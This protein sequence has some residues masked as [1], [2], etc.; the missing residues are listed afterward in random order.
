MS[1]DLSSSFTRAFGRPPE[2]RAR[3]PGRVNLIGEH[4]DY[5]DGFVL[6][7]PIPQQ[8]LVELTPTADRRV[9]A[10]SSTIEGSGVIEE[11]E[12]GLEA[13]RGSWLDYVMGT[14]VALAEALPEAARA[15]LSGFEVA[16]SS[17]VPVGSGLSSSAALEIGLLRALREAFS[18]DLDDVQLALLGRRAE[19]DFVGAPVGIMDQLA[20]SLGTP[21]SALFIDTRTLVHRRV[22]FPA[23]AELVVLDS[24]QR[25]EHGTGEYRTRRAEC[26]GAAALLGLSK[27]RD[28]TLEGVE[29]LPPPMNRRARHVL[30]ENARVLRAVDAM[31]VN[32]VATMGALFHASHASMRDDFEITTPEIDLLVELAAAEP[33]VFGARMTGGGF[34]GAVIALAARGHGRALAERVASGYRARTG[35]TPSVLLPEAAP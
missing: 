5:N 11:Y 10:A 8:T 14:T 17:R 7:M 1:L 3:A 18:L 21:G 20:S 16:V 15:R 32:D 23:R 9:R 28:A 34:G 31:E 26:D 25:H 19:N 35:R 27:L 2:V 13:K 6:P 4:T 29:G 12:L 30:T 33:E 24:G 22:P